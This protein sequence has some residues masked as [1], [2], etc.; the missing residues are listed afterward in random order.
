MV[1]FTKIVGESQLPLLHAKL[2]LACAHSNYTSVAPY[3][4]NICTTCRLVL[5]LR[6]CTNTRVLSVC[7]CF[8]HIG[9]CCPFVVNNGNINI[10]LWFESVSGA[11][12]LILP[13][14]FILLWRRR[15]DLQHLLSD[16][17][18]MHSLMN[19]HAAHFS[20]LVFTM[21]SMD[22]TCGLIHLKGSDG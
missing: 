2:L 1:C 12:I 20:L 7:L 17:G 5:V 3:I 11:G 21:S 19:H 15:S 14:F 9:K 6:Y 10:H 4:G 8:Q 18:L 22:I 13:S 16:K